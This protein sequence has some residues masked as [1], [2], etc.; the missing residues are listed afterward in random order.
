MQEDE[1]HVL[2]TMSREDAV[3]GL[4]TSELTIRFPYG[5][6][7]YEAPTESL[8]LGLFEG[9]RTVRISIP[10]LIKDSDQRVAYR[11]ERV[12]RVMVT[13]S[14][15]KANLHTA[16]L[17]NISTTGAQL[18][19][20]QDISL[21]E[22]RTGDRIELDIPLSEVIKIHSGATARH[23]SN[24]RIGVQF[25]PRLPQTIEEPLSRWIFLRREEERERLARHLDMAGNPAP[26]AG[27]SIP[28]RGILFVSPDE[29]LA[30]VLRE[31]LRDFRPVFRLAP[32]AQGLKDALQ[33][34]PS[35]TIFHIQETGL[36]M[37]RRMKTLV[38]I[39]QRKTPTLLLGTGVD[40]TSLFELSSEWK[41]S[42]AM[43][44]SLER[45]TFFQRLTQGII[46]RY[47]EGGDS[48]MA[49]ME[50]P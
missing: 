22:L 11:V 6:G 28:E 23:F 8:G 19:S 33:G 17:V 24:R 50:N 15:P 41:T 46:R 43:A 49:P 35:L 44:W 39:A 5:L 48:P 40:G 9:R 12:G 16:S 29:A 36:D 10:K 20:Q 32:T 21:E 2:A 3:Y 37:R 14:T 18:H 13:F 25:T 26:Q 7:F 31:N 30:E 1:L 27:A 45:A 47:S 34:R 42:S 38:E 4:R